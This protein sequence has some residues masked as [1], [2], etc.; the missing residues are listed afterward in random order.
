[1]N[2]TFPARGQ[3]ASLSGCLCNYQ[4][5]L[6]K[7]TS[8]VIILSCTGLQLLMAR[9]MNGQGLDDIKVT[10]ELKGEPLMTAFK[11]IEEQTNFRFAY[12]KKQ[13]DPQ[14]NLSL[15]KA[16]YTL[17]N[18]LE[19]ILA[20]T[21]LAFRQV[22]NKILIT[23]T[24]EPQP[25][26]LSREM[27]KAL[28]ARFDGGVR[29]KI[30]DE[31]DQ[32]VY[33]ASVVVTGIGKGTATNAEGQ[34]VITGIKPGKYRVEVT[35]LG[36]QTVVKDVNI[37]EGASQELN[38]QLKLSNSSMSE[39]VVTGY[40]KQ[41]KREVTGA[42]STISSD[43][44]TKSPVSD[45][46]SLLQG[47][48]AGVSVDGQ[49]GPGNEQVVR[50]RGIGTLG[51]NDPLYVIDGVQTKGGLNL[52]N[53]NDIE[54][55]TILK[56]AASCAL[57]GARGSSGVIVITTKRGK[58]GAPKLEYNSYIG[59]EVPRKGPDIMSPQQY[60]DAQWGFFKNSGRALS[61]PLFGTGTTP[62][63][64]DYLI[65][66]KTSPGFIGV[67]TG[68][69]AANPALYN[70]PTYRIMKANKSG[71]DWYDELFDP[72]VTQ[73]HQLA[74]SGA[75]DKSNY[76]VTM[77]Y[78]DNKG[79]LLY[80]FFKRYSL[81]ANTEFKV[82]PWF[83]VGEN[84]QFSYTQG[85]TV[86]DHNDQNVFSQLYSTSPLLPVYD[87][88]GKLAG[89]AGAGS[90]LALGDN[91]VI[92]RIGSKESKGY[93]ARMF[94]S[95]YAEVEP[96][97]NLV[98]QTKVA[99][100][101]LPFQS[102]FFQDTLPQVAF[103]V[104]SY[105]F[106]EFAGH[107]L[108]WRITNKISY[109]ILINQVHKLNAFVAYEASEFNYRGLGASTDSLLYNLP[110][111]QVV[112][113]RTASKWLVDGGRDRYTYA[114]EIGNLNYSLLDR[115]LASF[116]IRRDGTSRF[117]KFKRYG[118]F[119]SASVGWRVSGEKFA[120]NI[121][122]LDEFK[123][124]GSLGT[125]GNDAIGTGLT[126]NQYYT[127]PIYTYYDLAVLNNSANLGFALTQIG[128]PLLQWEVN[129]TIN[130][131]F[132]AILFNNSL[133][134]SF[135]WFNRKTDK[136][137]FAPPVTAL[138]GDAGAPYQNIMN[139]TNK[140][141]ELELGYSGPRKTRLTYDINFN[142]ATYRNNVTYI[143][144]HP[145][146]F[147]SG[148]LYARAIPL[149]RSK[150]GY[151]VGSFFGFIYD[152][153]IQTG[154][155]AGHFRFKDISGPLGKPDGKVDDNDRTFIGSPHPSFSYGLNI[156]LAYKNFDMSIF[157][158][159][160]QGNKIFNYW[161]AFSEWPGQQTVGSL[162]TWTPTNTGAKLPIFNDVDLDDD[163]PS[164]FFVENGSYLR[165]KSVQLGY[166]VPRIKGISRLRI[167]AQAWNL[168]TI[169]NYSGLEPEVNTGSP[170]SAGI[171]FGGNFPISKK[172]LFGVNLGL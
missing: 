132:D 127:D 13:V 108:E 55:I 151:P 77:N 143:D 36:F 154:D 161:R 22:N 30:I 83:R 42:V 23:R 153:M 102:R 103:P 39:V 129:Q 84:I 156:N 134:V 171:D 142:I 130:L 41:S 9:D 40:S 104:N 136:L 59:Y 158:Q 155:S 92:G 96:I 109:S 78:L 112:S 116:T 29:G 88:N 8:L 148:G 20:G 101:Y 75:T 141:I 106:N 93:T 86:S 27:K 62:V 149:S 49:G 138:Q 38:F 45:V 43:V 168:F 91:P 35:A 56:D 124:R 14:Q 24:D 3:S 144:G 28:A 44:I 170:G 113:S 159:G 147:I 165:F 52:I 73:S 140:G 135:N 70:F 10:L 15:Q 122:W 123:L 61:S 99:I 164:T 80:S 157:L 32:P 18:A 172:I 105:K 150:V 163:R 160:V 145:E 63:V 146:T 47:R 166:T 162:D 110:G 12:I 34:F 152:G 128:N 17:R 26:E 120:Q 69:P 95:A 139:F 1:M 119:P 57:Y 74:I 107:S 85:N 167:Y 169:T 66:K 5:W 67:A 19:L 71:T 50:I 115:Y 87:I 46:T 90:S 37:A 33:A 54:S 53:P 114:S 111:F 60:A 82:T 11:K 7:L 125:S 126:E 89:T 6:M 16:E 121:T 137:L 48:V 2:F 31:R 117:T 58:T 76:A 68:D 81:R 72:A 21:N 133:N 118:V 97:K 94:G 64:P 65:G 25:E 131:G 100:D 79:I 4:R 51:D 98:L